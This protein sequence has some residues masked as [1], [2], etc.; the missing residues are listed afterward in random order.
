[1]FYSV[2]R[3]NKVF[4][5]TKGAKANNNIYYM[6]VANILEIEYIYSILYW[7]YKKIIKI[8][9]KSYNDRERDI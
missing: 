2:E 9:L 6:S 5:K 1:M 7:Y 4:L 8:I 3:E